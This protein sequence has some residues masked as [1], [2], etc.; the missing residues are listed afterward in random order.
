ML[1]P[2]LTCLDIS[3]CGLD[4]LPPALAALTRLADLGAAHNPL[5]LDAAGAEETAAV[6]APL[7]RLAACLTRL[8]LCACGGVGGLPPQL[9][10]CS[11]LE[12]LRLG[13]RGV[14]QGDGALLRTLCSMRLRS[15]HLSDHTAPWNSFFERPTEA[16]RALAP[17]TSLCLARCPGA[18]RPRWG[19]GM[20]SLPRLAALQALDLTACQLERLPQQLPALQVQCAGPPAPACHVLACFVCAGWPTEVLPA[21]LLLGAAFAGSSA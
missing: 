4:R 19:H 2:T 9:L 1:G 11:R 17:V 20:P 12:E 13:G 3:G 15:L 8:D 6:F 21:C 18:L 16:E 14:R 5:L 7:A 10:L